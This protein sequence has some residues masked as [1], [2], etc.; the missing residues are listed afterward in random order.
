[1]LPQKPAPSDDLGRLQ[2]QEKLMF[3]NLNEISGLPAISRVK[4]GQ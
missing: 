3:L 2:G 1:M 4:S